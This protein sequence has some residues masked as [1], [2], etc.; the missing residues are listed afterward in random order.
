MGQKM[1]AKMEAWQWKQGLQPAVQ[2]AWPIPCL[3]PAS[4]LVAS[5]RPKRRP[6][7]APATPAPTKKDLWTNVPISLSVLEEGLAPAPENVRLSSYG[8]PLVSSGLLLTFGWLE[9]SVNGALP[10]SGC[11]QPARTKLRVIVESDAG[12]V[13]FRTCVSRVAVSVQ[14]GHVL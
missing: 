12:S 13:F 1:V 9:A 7:S 2:V 3:H 8:F 6:K 14:C 4:R 11:S 10:L 5:K